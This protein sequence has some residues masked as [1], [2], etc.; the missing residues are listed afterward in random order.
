LLKVIKL[1]KIVLHLF[2]DLYLSIWSKQANYSEQTPIPSYS[3]SKN[4]RKGLSN[5]NFHFRGQQDFKKR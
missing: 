5:F 1:L 2:I 3:T 4:L